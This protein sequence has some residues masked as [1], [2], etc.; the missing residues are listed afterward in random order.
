MLMLTRVINVLYLVASLGLPS[1]SMLA[2][3]ASMPISNIAA[4]LALSTID[5]GSEWEF[6]AMPLK[7]H[8]SPLGE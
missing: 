3:T 1:S 4:S 7:F 6:M 2:Y 5:Y 8:F